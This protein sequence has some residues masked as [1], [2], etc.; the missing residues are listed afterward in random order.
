MSKHGLMKVARPKNASPRARP[1]ET[2]AGGSKQ[3][4]PNN[5]RLQRRLPL[6][7]RRP[8]FSSC[9]ILQFHRQFPKILRSA[10]RH[11]HRLRQFGQSP[12]PPHIHRQR[13]G[14]LFH[15]PQ[16]YLWPL[17][18]GRPSERQVRERPRPRATLRPSRHQ[19][20][21]RHDCHRQPPGQRHFRHRHSAYKQRLS[22]STRHSKFR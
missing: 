13:P 5:R 15:C 19:G 21:P 3:A 6:L 9:R 14:N 16:T 4:I 1:S 18:P 11:R 8:P 2:M 12:H 17:Q 20:P 10:S 22:A 7:F